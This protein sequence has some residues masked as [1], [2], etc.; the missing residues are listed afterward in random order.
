M[1]AFRPI[2][3]LLI[4]AS[5]PL[6]GFE[7]PAPPV[8]QK[9]DAI[10]PPTPVVQPELNFYQAPKPL[11]PEAVTSDWRDFLGPTH[12]G[13]SPETHLVTSFG[14][15]GPAKVWEVSRGEGYAAAAAIDDKVVIF[16]RSGDNEVMP[17]DIRWGA[18]L[19]NGGRSTAALPGIKHWPRAV[20]T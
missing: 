19:H 1:H 14:E 8:P 20:G 11:S 16:H 10:I 5:V 18:C 7:D 12:N 15:T 13:Y 4:A 6:A 2:V 9:L 3:A 17:P